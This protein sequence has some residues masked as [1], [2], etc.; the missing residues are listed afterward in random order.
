MSCFSGRRTYLA[1]AWPASGRG[2]S[3]GARNSC[4]SQI[5]TGED[6][7]LK[8]GSLRLFEKKVISICRSDLATAL[9]VAVIPKGC[10]SLEATGGTTNFPRMVSIVSAAA[11]PQDGKCRYTAQPN[12]ESCRVPMDD[13]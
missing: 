5:L 3:L 11:P 7:C 4:T 13:S 2:T 9:G 12:S 6:I 8:E 10:A 1:A